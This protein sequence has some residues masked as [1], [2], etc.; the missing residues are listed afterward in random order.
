MNS[1]S[2]KTQKQQR[3]FYLI[4]T[5]AGIALAILHTIRNKPEMARAMVIA[6]AF[7]LIVEFLIPPVG[8]RLFQL[9]MRLARVLGAINTALLVTIVFFTVITPVG[10]LRRLVLKSSPY[11]PESCRKN[12]SSWFKLSDEHQYTAPF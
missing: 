7:F 1:T 6:A 9:W 3:Q 2:A 5:A 12:K 4:M 10:F 11:S 8:R